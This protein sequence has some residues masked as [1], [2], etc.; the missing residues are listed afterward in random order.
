MI[1][2]VGIMT[3][4]GHTALHAIT[5]PSHEH[6]T[7]ASTHKKDHCH[8]AP[9]RSHT[10]TFSQSG[11]A[12]NSLTIDRCDEVIVVNS[13][14]RKMI[15]ALGPHTHHATYPGFTETS[16]A[17]GEVHR[18]QAALAGTYPL[19]DHDDDSLVTTLIIE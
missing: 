3:L 17:P 13:L 15:T 18:F 8:D 5:Q 4:A 10:V 16:L 7:N 11:V 14:G 9:A 2:I 19:H 12:P 6:S 1:Y